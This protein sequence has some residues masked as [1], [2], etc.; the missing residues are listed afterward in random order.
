MLD[1]V[2][3]QLDFPLRG[4]RWHCRGVQRRAVISLRNT[5]CSCLYTITEFGEIL[6]P[7]EWALPKHPLYLNVWYVLN[8]V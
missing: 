5:L 4:L 3:N 2:E 1:Q 6:F 8:I 7:C